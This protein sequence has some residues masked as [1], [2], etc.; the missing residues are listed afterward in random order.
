VKWVRLK[1]SKIKVFGKKG[2]TLPKGFQE[3]HTSFLHSLLTNDIRGLKPFSFNY[4]LWLRQNGSPI[5]DFFVYKLED[6]YLLDT[7][8]EAKKIIEEFERLKLS[9]KVYFEDLTTFGHIFVF[10]EYAK[11]WVEK[12]FGMVPEEGKFFEKDGVFVAN[13]PLRIREEGFDVFGK[14]DGLELPK[15]GQITEEDFEDLRIERKVPRIRKELR[16]G[17][18]PLE[19]GLLNVA[20]SLTKGCYVGQEVIARIHYK[21]RLPRTL[22]LFK[23]E[24]LQEEQKVF[25]GEKEVGLIT[26][27]SRKG[28]ALGYILTTKLEEKREFS[29]ATG[30]VAVLD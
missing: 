27:V 10:G 2:K 21:G 26:S 23:G 9:L 24:N 18:S 15:E 16:E 3:E 1:R 4:N 14:L 30:K 8:G 19:A 28:L 5:E 29:T 25:D 6:A 22:V 17:Y 13:N 7:E 11:D 12:T 20:I